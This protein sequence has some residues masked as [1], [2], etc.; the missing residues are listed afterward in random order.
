VALKVLTECLKLMDKDIIRR[1]VI[2]SFK[3]SRVSVSGHRGE[4]VPREGAYDGELRRILTNWLTTQ[5]GCNVAGQWHIVTTGR[6]DPT[7]R[8]H[9][10]CDIVVEDLTADAITLLLGFVA[11][12][13]PDVVR[14]HFAWVGL[15]QKEL[16]SDDSWV[17]HFT[18]ED[19]YLDHPIWQSSQQLE[20]GINV[21]HVWRDLEVSKILISARW[22]DEEGTIHVVEKQ[23]VSS[24]DS[25]SML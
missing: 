23:L 19:D 18:C 15:S 2:C 22:K 12:E 20:E 1:A 9:S 25:E 5:E 4:Y 11:T 6:D 3:K 14:E 13:T 16:S 24:L 7:K 21:L 10:Y 17:V 8:Q